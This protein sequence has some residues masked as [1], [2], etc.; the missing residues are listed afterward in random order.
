MWQAKL[1]RPAIAEQLGLAVTQVDK[2]LKNLRRRGLQL[3]SPW[4]AR[5]PKTEAVEALFRQELTFKEVMARSV[6]A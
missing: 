5:A 6:A 1:S 3:R 2:C 4:P